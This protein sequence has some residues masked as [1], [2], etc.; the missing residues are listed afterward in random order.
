VGLLVGVLA[1]AAWRSSSLYTTW[2]LY[3]TFKFGWGPTRER[4]VAVRGGHRLGGGAGRLL[5][6]CS[7]ASRR[8]GW[9]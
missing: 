1:L 3:G 7:S 8:S 6:G 5:G 9:R 2:V 4:L